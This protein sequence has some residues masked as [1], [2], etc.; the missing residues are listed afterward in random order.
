[1]PTASSST[2]YRPF[3]E[4]F[5]PYPEAQIGSEQQEALKDNKRTRSTTVSSVGSSSDASTRAT[6]VSSNSSSSGKH[7][8]LAVST[9]LPPRRSSSPAPTPEK[10]SP[11][12]KPKRK[13]ANPGATTSADLASIRRLEASVLRTA[14]HAGS[15]DAN[16]YSPSYVETLL[17]DAVAS[18]TELKPVPTRAERKAAK[19]AQS[20]AVRMRKDTIKKELLK[21]A[22]AEEVDYEE[23]LKLRRGIRSGLKAEPMDSEE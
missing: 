12:S 16:S 17:A 5:A 11:K 4:R 2:R 10:S 9:F 6:S 23:A 7:R 8:K 20:K 18:S 13:R 15:I 3:S 1:M 22:G 19:K 21:E 14:L